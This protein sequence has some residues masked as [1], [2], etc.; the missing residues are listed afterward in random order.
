MFNSSY[1][2]ACLKFLVIKEIFKAVEPPSASERMRA[3]SNSF[4]HQ[5]QFL[6]IVTR[7]AIPQD[8]S[9]KGH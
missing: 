3:E 1:W 4:P 9:R 7:W 8:G 6:A 5:V 2:R